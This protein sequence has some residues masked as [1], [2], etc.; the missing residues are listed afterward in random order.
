[1]HTLSSPR[2]LASLTGAD[3]GTSPWRTISQEHV[4]TFADLTDDHQWIHVDV[5]R[6][7]DGPFGGT[8]AHGM[9]TLA[10]VPVLVG[11]VLRVEGSPFGLNYGFDKVR[12][13]SP[14][15]A[16]SR[17]RGAVRVDSV[18]DLDGWVRAGFEVTVEV[19]GSD[20]PA[21]V[22]VNLVQWSL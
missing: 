13:T 4:D 19:E 20:R 1:M 6:A 14:V 17:V 21:L 16:G 10:Y 15:R 2:E 8:V 22:A 3:L 7:A 5:E 12:F 9:L 18:T 11:E